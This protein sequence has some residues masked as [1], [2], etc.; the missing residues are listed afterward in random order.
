MCVTI[1]MPRFQT[2]IFF[3]PAAFHPPRSPCHYAQNYCTWVRIDRNRRVSHDQTCLLYQR[4]VTALLT[5]SLAPH[6]IACSS[7][8]LCRFDHSRCCL[9]VRDHHT[10][11]MMS[12]RRSSVDAVSNTYCRTRIHV[13][14]RSDACFLVDLGSHA[15]S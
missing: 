10:Y 11:N 8:L 2:R 12:L 5:S 4:F 6:L 3:S 9:M 7:M 1:R 15:W 14:I 13:S